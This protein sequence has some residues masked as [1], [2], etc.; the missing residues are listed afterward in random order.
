[1]TVT[2]DFDLKLLVAFFS[3]WVENSYYLE[4]KMCSGFVYFS[5][6]CGIINYTCTFR[7]ELFLAT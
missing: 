7:T 6:I 4:G 1:M 5:E 2:F 3:L